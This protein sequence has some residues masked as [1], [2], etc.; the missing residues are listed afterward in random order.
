MPS[1]VFPQTNFPR[2][3][4]LIDNGVMPA[5]E[6]MANVT[7]PVEEAMKDIPGTVN[8]RSAT[9]RGSAEVNVFFDWSTNM[10]QAELYVLGRLAQIRSVLPATATT[11]VHRLNVYRVSDHRHQPDKHDAQPGRRLGNRALRH[12]SALSYGFPVW[13]ASASSVAECRSITSLVDPARVKAHQ[14][15]LVEVDKALS[16]TNQF[17]PVG[18]HEENYQLYLVVVDDRLRTQQDIE[19]AVVGWQRDRRPCEFAILGPLSAVRPR[20]STA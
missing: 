13:R 7:R 17:T 18:M 14:M 8:I 16:E 11:Q 20:H 1:S 12:L 19:D 3:V 2:V 6:M 5:D 4:I 9:S 15:T 10:P